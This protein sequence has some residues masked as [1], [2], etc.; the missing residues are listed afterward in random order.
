MQSTTVM[1]IYD[2]IAN[3]VFA[4]QVLQPLIAKTMARPHEQ[5]LLVS[6]EKNCSTAKAVIK[7]PLPRNLQ[8]HVL[9]KLPFFGRPS[10]W[11]ARWQLKTLLKQCTRYE[12]IARGPLAGFIAVQSL[13]KMYCKKLTVQA[14]GLLAEEYRYAH[15][16]SRWLHRLKAA[17]YEQIE[18]AIYSTNSI[19]IETVSVALKNYLIDYFDA[20][21]N[22]ITL[23]TD[24]IP[25]AVPLTK[26]L[27]A[28]HAIR[29]ELNIAF[30]ALVYCYNGSAKPWQCPE[31]VIIF[32][33]QERKTT[34][35]LLLMI[36]TQDIRYFQRLCAQYQ[37]PHIVSHTHR[38][39]HYENL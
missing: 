34:M 8:I 32:F 26:K 28:R 16:K 10:L 27:A 30:D 33:K 21:K 18:R 7:E 4:G 20:P 9:K 2:G 3:S 23:A 22:N 11:F 35:P 36:L 12:L 5:F 17:A 6:F 39:P 1:I 29:T 14:R 31:D 19:A 25:L 38:Y 37:L 24:D 15:G 13:N